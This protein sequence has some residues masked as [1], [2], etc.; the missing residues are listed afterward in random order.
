M[1][2]LLPD[3]IQCARDKQGDSGNAEVK[4]WTK[5]LHLLEVINKEY[6]TEWH[7]D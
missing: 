4:S 3:M 6:N 1:V 2:P 7:H 5:L